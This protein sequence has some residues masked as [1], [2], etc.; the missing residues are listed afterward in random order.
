MKITTRIL[1]L[2]ALLLTACSR[3]NDFPEI[4][5]A[6]KA[7]AFPLLKEGTAASIWTDKDDYPVVGICAEFLA[8]DIE[9]VGQ[10]RPQLATASSIDEVE[11]K[12]VVIAGT[13]G[14]SALIDSIVSEGKI[15]VSGI[16]GKWE[17]FIVTT[18]R[19]PSAGVDKAFV[20]VGSDRRGTAFGLTSLCEAIGVSPWYWWADVTPE[21]ESALFIQKG[22]FS[23]GEPSV[24]YRGFFINDERFGGWAKW[25]ENTFE[26]ETHMVGPK[27]YRM[28]FELLLRLKE[29]GYMRILS[30]D[31]SVLKGDFLV[32]CRPDER[33][34]CSVRLPRQTES[35]LMLNILDGGA[36][37][38]EFALGEYIAAS[39]FDWS[40]PDLGD[41]TIAVDFALTRISLSVDDWNRT[42]E[43]NVEI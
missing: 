41:L 35:S 1:C 3:G 5:N 42:F 15:D 14:H 13:I 24:R 29:Q 25:S 22:E 32:E 19:K 18:L 37:V 27:T 23:Q 26:T 40:S 39:G 16:E 34:V 10:V 33:G 9:R 12:N 38:R 20:I 2:T 6:D 8:D 11:G 31:G 17:S 21:T 43:F 4:Y 30:P 36:S 7:G 28:V